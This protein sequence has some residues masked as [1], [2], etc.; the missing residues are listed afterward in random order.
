[1]KNELKM[2][3]E[4]INKVGGNGWRGRRVGTLCNIR[5]TWTAYF[6]AG[7]Y[8]PDE[9]RVSYTRSLKVSQNRIRKEIQTNAL[10][11]GIE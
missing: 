5:G 11:G 1:M 7:V 2:N 10:N 3:A 9:L 4:L 8:T 6:D